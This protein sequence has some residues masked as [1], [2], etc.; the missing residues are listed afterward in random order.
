MQDGY[1]LEDAALRLLGF[2]LWLRAD[3]GSASWSVRIQQYVFVGGLVWVYALDRL[4][5]HALQIPLRECGA[6]EILDRAD[7]LGHL[8]GLLVLYGRHLALTELLTHF[9]IVAEVEFGADEDDRDAR[10][11]VFDF[12]EP[13]ECTAKVSDKVEAWMGKA[14]AYLRFDVI[15]G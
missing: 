6:L 7:L 8:H 11:V 13:L 4:V 15:E 5:E 14:G 12:R 9:R 1:A 3:D 2:R 10:G